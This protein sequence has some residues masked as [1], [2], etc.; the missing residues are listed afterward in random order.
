M[1]IW[2]GTSGFQYR[3]WRGAFYPEKLSLAAMLPFYAQRFSSTESNYSFRRIPSA[4]TIARLADATPERFKVSFKAPQKITHFAKLRECAPTVLFFQSAIAPLGAKLG[5]VL[6]QLPPQLRKDVDL[7]RAF[8]G[9]LP[10]GLH[11]A[12]EFRHASWFSD[13]VLE[14]LRRADVALCI[15]ESA[16][17]E[18]PAAVTASFGYLRLRREDYSQRDLKRWAAF[19][20][21]QASQWQDVYIYF[22]HEDLGVGPKFAQQMAR[23]LDSNN[24]G[25]LPV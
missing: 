24:Q 25:E 22:K 20:R 6:F 2:I 23:L 10:E 5:A 14:E 13:D 11:A 3:E 9:D 8:I 4:K 1:R 16:D 7:L 15:A 21:A 17:L 18:T 12:F 19:V